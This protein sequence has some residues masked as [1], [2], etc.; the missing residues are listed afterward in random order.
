MG[1]VGVA[2]GLPG[3]CVSLGGFEFSCLSTWACERVLTWFTEI[4]PFLLV[5]CCPIVVQP[6]RASPARRRS[7]VCLII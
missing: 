2:L 6:E 4:V 7:A 5:I 3:F 1:R